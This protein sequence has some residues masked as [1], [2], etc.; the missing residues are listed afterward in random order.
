[1][2]GGNL[3]GVLLEGEEVVLERRVEIILADT[4]PGILTQII[5]GLEID[6][7]RCDGLLSRPAV[8]DG[9]DELT[10]D[11][12]AEGIFPAAVEPVDQH[13]E[14]LAVVDAGVEFAL[15]RKARQR[16][17]AAAHDGVDGMAALVAVGQI[18]LGMEALAQIELHAD[19]ATLQL[20]REP[21]QRSLSGLGRIAQHELVAKLL[22]NLLLA[23]VH[24]VGI[25]TAVAVGI[26]AAHGI[27]VGLEHAYDETAAAMDRLPATFIDEFAFELIDA[28]HDAV[29][30]PKVE[31]AHAEVDTP[32]AV[33]LQLF[34]QAVNKFAVNIVV[35]GCH[36]LLVFLGN[37]RFQ[38]QM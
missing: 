31:V 4:L 29:P 28:I 18:E 16:E 15:T 36:W 34:Q 17:V 20:G 10:G 5:G 22:G 24:V 8:V 25:G 38:M 35:Y 2:F 23:L 33:V 14:L 26:E 7:I 1:M 12:H 3:H 11:V 6:I 9:I 13:V 19:L 30:A 32:D 21:A 37:T 27:V